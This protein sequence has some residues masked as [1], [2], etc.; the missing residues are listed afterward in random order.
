MAGEVF[1]R[2]SHDLWVL[3]LTPGN[4]ADRKPELYLK[5]EF[6]ET[7]G[8]FSPDSRFI[9][10]TSNASGR[11]EIYVQPFPTASDGK[12]KVSRGGGVAPRWRGDGKELFYISADSKMMAVEVSTNPVF[13]AGIPKVLFQAPIWGGGTAHQRDPLRRDRRWKEIPDQQRAG[14][15]RRS[16]PLAY[17][18]GAE[19]DGAAKEMTPERWREVEQVYQSTMDREPRLRAAFL[20]EACGSD[21]ELRREV[22]SL[23]ELNHSPVLVDAAG[24]AGCGGVTHRQ[25][26]L[27]R[28]RN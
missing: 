7:Q 9:A 12:R 16:A 28:V 3:P 25:H 2:A 23:L 17:H 27:A 15:S 11:D 4:P 8:Q 13:K 18:G 24:M 6:N 19:L 1:D 10:Y 5:T 20:S 14:G 26:Q 21:H 22:D